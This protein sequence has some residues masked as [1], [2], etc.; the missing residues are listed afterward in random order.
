MSVVCKEKSTEL[1]LTLL[2]KCV[3]NIQFRAAEFSLA[4]NCSDISDKILYDAIQSSYV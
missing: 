1:L 3:L 2:L 4:G